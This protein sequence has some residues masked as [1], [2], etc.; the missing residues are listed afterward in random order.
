MRTAPRKYA[1]LT[2]PNVTAGTGQQSYVTMLTCPSSGSVVNS[3]TLLAATGQEV[4]ASAHVQKNCHKLDVRLVDVSEPVVAR[5]GTVV[6]YVLAARSRCIK[7]VQ[8][9]LQSSASLVCPTWK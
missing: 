9:V 2:V 5:C 6:C 3:A 4:V 7:H 1:E 8:T